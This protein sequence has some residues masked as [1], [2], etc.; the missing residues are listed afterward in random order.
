MKWAVF[1]VVGAGV[2]TGLVGYWFWSSAATRDEIRAYCQATR[3]GHPWAEAKQR[4]QDK[5]FELVGYGGHD[6]LVFTETMDRRYG[7]VVVVD[8]DGVV[9]ETRFAE[10]PAK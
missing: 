8:P 9:L 6:Q 7:C 10:L 2:L 1:F 5:G 3:R 4:A